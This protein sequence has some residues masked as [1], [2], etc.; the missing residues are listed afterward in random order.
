M[1]E[2]TKYSTENRVA[3]ITIN[4]PEKRNALNPALV[5]ELTDQFLRAGHDN[6]AKVVVLKAAGEVFSAGADLEYLQQLQNNSSQ[7][8]LEDT[9]AIK[10]LLWNIYTLPKLV[11]AQVEGHAIAGGC[12]LAA[13]CDVVYAVPES[14]FGYTEVRIG[15]IPA[16]VS[17][18]LVRKLGEGRA[19]ELLLSG[20]LIDAATASSYGLINFVTE[21]SEIAS[22]VRNYAER[23]AVSAS[24]QSVALTKQ[25]LHTAQNL[26]LEESLEAAIKLNVQTR[27]SE[28][29]KKGIASFLNKEKLGW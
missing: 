2:L 1:T 15:F 16:L 25:L 8:D 26:N 5:E 14:K 4:R 24:G 21:K 23:M 13:V 7:D 12:G 19:K 11:V 17:C 29:C 27:S 10:E 20:D 18:F 9:I 22:S 28:D 6:D 3:Y